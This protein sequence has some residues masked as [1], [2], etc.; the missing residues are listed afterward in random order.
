LCAVDIT[1]RSYKPA[2]FDVLHE[3][4]QVC[5]EAEIAYSKR[6][7]R[8]YLRLRGADCVVAE[9]AGKVAGFCISAQQ[10]HY[11]YIVTI[12]VLEE[13]RRHKVGTALLDEIE[14]R[15]IAS[16]VHEVRL[17]T[18]TD[19]DSAVAFWQKHGYRKRGIRKNY[20]PNGR[21]AFA[22]IKTLALAETTAKKTN[23]TE[24]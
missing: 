12:D 23:D 13:F 1:L 20:Y 7:L 21:D 17:E 14:R 8:E 15:L 4:D 24:N 19:N 16:G 22:M 10:D 11:G 18:A 6:E 3:I 9:A 2:D 5:Y